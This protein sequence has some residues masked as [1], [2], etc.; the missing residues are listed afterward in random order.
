MNIA[1]YDCVG[2]EF[3][4]RGVIPNGTPDDVRELVMMTQINALE[5][6]DSMK[7]FFFVAWDGKREGYSSVFVLD[8]SDHSE[9]NEALLDS[10]LNKALKLTAKK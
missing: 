1:F 4:E 5:S 8:E 3:H 9:L 6:G 10:I 7:G 2:G